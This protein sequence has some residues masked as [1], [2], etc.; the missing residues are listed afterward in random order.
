MEPFMD[1]KNHNYKSLQTISTQSFV[2]GFCSHK[3][4]SQKGYSI[5]VHEDGSGAQK[6]GIYICPN[7]FGPTFFTLD[8]KRIPSSPIGNIVTNVPKELEALYEESRKSASNN[9]YTAAVLICRKM[10]MNISVNLGAA[11]G[12]KFVEY[13]EYL[14]NQGYTPPNG[15]HW[16]DHIRKKGNEATHE[17]ALMNEADAKDLITFTE[18]LL[19][20]I[21]EFPNM[22]PLSTP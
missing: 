14:S 18:M 7:C 16:V 11:P 19:K 8:G 15:K 21:Y 22:V 10:L 20:F 3:V 2:C 17:I 4:S 9:C 6:G 5:G 12:L 13:V 1:G